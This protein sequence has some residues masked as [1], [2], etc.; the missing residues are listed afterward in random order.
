MYNKNDTSLYLCQSQLL[1][2]NVQIT[3][4]T[5]KKTMRKEVIMVKN[6]IDWNYQLCSPL[7]IVKSY[8]TFTARCIKFTMLLKFS[9]LALR[10]LV[11][12]II[13]REQVFLYGS[14][15]S[16]RNICLK[17][18][19]TNELIFFCVLFVSFSW[20]LLVNFEVWEW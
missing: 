16:L 15:C 10:F 1:M 18:R 12:I 14:S 8:K 3:K 17:L 19:I 7:I 5:I 6:I 11:K 9:A 4:M 13:K 2:I 20:L